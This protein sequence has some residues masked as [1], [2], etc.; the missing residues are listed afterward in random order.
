MSGTHSNANI[1]RPYLLGRRQR[2]ADEQDRKRVRGNGETTAA[3]DD[4]LDETLVALHRR[5]QAED[6]SGKDGRRVTRRG[7]GD[8]LG[9]TRSHGAEKRIGVSCSFDRACLLLVPGRMLLVF[10][11]VSASRAAT[12]NEVGPALCR[13]ACRREWRVAGRCG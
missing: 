13:H 11:L 1:G 12:S 4:R 7:S 6:L 8:V 3:T 9:V 5:M 2:C 10:D